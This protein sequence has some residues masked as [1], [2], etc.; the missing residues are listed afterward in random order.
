M[1][2]RVLIVF[3]LLI[4]L[5][6]AGC[7]FY[8]L[9][10]MRAFDKESVSE[11]VV[12]EIEKGESLFSV[13]ERLEKLSLIRN[14]NVVKVYVRFFNPSVVKNGKYELNPGMTPFEILSVLEKGRQDLYKVTIPE[15]LTS[16]QIASIFKKNGVI[17]SETAFLDMLVSTELIESLGVAGESLEGYLYPDTYY[18]Q[19]DF[20][21]EKII[22]HMV[23]TFFSVLSS[24]YPYYKDFSPEKMSE[25]IILASII[26]KE[27]RVEEEAPLMASVF[28]NRLN[29]GMPLQSCATVV[30][31]ITEK[32]GRDHPG[33][34]YLR[35]LELESP[36]NTYYNQSLPPAPISNPG[37]V[38][39]DAAFNPAQTDYLFFV[40]KNSEAGTHSFSSNYSDHNQARDQ[41]LS[42]F[43]S[44]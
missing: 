31:V 34:I 38:A 28:Y 16:R 44:K 26:E 2:K 21:P 24:I 25:K 35:D 19:K 1:A 6:A 20:P 30:Y 3:L 40:V 27:Y 14:A 29:I 37:T 43:R 9:T 39:L 4:F 7:M 17:S 12:F 41:Y 11:N 15:G 10:N 18:F 8:Y 23:R 22:S 36:Y 33:R 13:L 42:G 32:L 5:S